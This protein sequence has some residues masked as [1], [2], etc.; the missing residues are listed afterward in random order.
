MFWFEKNL[1][2]KKKLFFK[3]WK[4]EHFKK[5]KGIFENGKK[6][7]LHTLYRPYPASMFT[8]YVKMKTRT[9]IMIIVIAKISTAF[10]SWFN[11]FQNEGKRDFPNLSSESMIANAVNIWTNP[12]FF[13]FLSFEIIQSSCTANE[14]NDVNDI[15]KKGN[16]CLMLQLRY[17]F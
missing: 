14:W 15:R 4:S 17:D 10:S 5:W 13:F 8:Q 12:K 9:E 2:F 6:S 11:V 16:G 1:N 7:D 3:K